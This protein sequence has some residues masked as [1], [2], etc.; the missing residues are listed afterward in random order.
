MKN[1][2][3]AVFG[4]FLV[5]AWAAFAGD[6]IAFIT[7][8]KGEIAVD[9]NPRP[10][11]L[12]E[13]TRGQKIIVGKE[14][15]ASVMY[16][17]TGK[18]YVLKGPGDYLVKDNE[19]TG[20]AGMP[21]T[22]RETAWRATNKVLAQ[23]A[24]TSAASVRMRSIGHSKSEPDAKLIYPVQGN[25]STLQPTFRWKT[26]DAKTHGDFVLMVAGQ[27]KPVHI[28]KAAGG[29]YRVPARLLPEKEY[30]WTVTVAGSELGNGSFRTLSSE[31]LAQIERRRP[32][33]KAE[34]S[35]RVLFTLMLQ[36]MGATQEAREAWTKLSEERA[37]L[38]ELA[39]FAK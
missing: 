1:I 14:S 24:Q 17:S 8:I 4:L 7:N 33:E 34:F 11:L 36:E 23:V 39:A 25:V 18:E 29:S 6:G 19:I 15:Q 35:D 32:S 12:S 38:P 22:T 26:A 3:R 30:S 31:A 13:L 27:E 2:Q 10:A 28:A 16:I 9:G 37:D 5:A 21:P 20:S